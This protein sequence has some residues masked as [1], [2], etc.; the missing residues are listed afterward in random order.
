MY[1]CFTYLLADHRCT[2]AAL[3]GVAHCVF[4][5]SAESSAGIACSEQYGHS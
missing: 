4:H 3:T 1:K 2:D 5:I